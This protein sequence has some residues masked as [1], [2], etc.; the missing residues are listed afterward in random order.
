MSSVSKFTFAISSPDEFLV[1]L[2]NEEKTAEN[3]D[4]LIAKLLLCFRISGSQSL[5][6]MSD[7]DRKLE[8]VV[9]CV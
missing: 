5:I 3:V 4:R 6:A 7:C 2:Y 9:S 8:I 1:N